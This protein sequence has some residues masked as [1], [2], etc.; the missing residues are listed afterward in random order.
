MPRI[1]GEN[2]KNQL[3]IRDQFSGDQIILYYRMPTTEERVGYESAKYHRDKD[4]FEIRLSEAGQI[5]GEKILEGFSE[6]SFVQKIGEEM[7]P[8]SS[9]SKSPNHD[10]EWK[11]LLRKYAAD[12][13]ETLSLHVFEGTT[14]IASQE[15]IRKN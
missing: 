8:F 10:P 15:K 5:F 3:I 11:Q 6:G 7:K 4:G 14:V 9:D 2:I 12:I 13:L 1:I